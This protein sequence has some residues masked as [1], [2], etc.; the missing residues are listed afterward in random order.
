M[1]EIELKPHLKKKRNHEIVE[2]WV[3]I[4][5]FCLLLTESSKLRITAEVLHNDIKGMYI[6]SSKVLNY[7]TENEGN[8]FYR[9]V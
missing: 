9:I 7:E 4:I 1:L 3:P 5:L 8:S 6:Q 2:G